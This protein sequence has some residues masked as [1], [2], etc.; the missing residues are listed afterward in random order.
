MIQGYVNNPEATQSSLVRSSDGQLLFKCNDLVTI[1]QKDPVI[2]VVTGRADRTVNVRGARVGLD[3][4]TGII[5]KLQEVK[6]CALVWNSDTQQLFC[7]CVLE[8][9]D[10][11]DLATVR[12]KLSEQLT[13]AETP[14]RFVVIPELPLNKRTK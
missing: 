6:D 2:L 1:L 8:S 13:H 3:R 12:E 5:K 11:N 4:V 7:F 9:G 14:S 10:K